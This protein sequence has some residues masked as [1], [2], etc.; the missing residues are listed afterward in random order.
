MRDVLA[1]AL[2]MLVL[3]GVANGQRLYR[4][5]LDDAAQQALKAMDKV[6]SKELFD[7]MLQNLS[8]QSRQDFETTFSGIRRQTRDRIQT[9]DNWCAV[10]ADMV[11]TMTR[12]DYP[13]LVPA[14]PLFATTAAEL[15]AE[16]GRLLEKDPAKA[17]P[18]P[19]ID[20][21]NELVKQIETAK[22]D[23]QKEIDDLTNNPGTAE[24]RL[25]ALLGQLGNLTEVEQALQ[26]FQASPSKGKLHSLA[27][28]ALETVG[29]LRRL[30]EAYQEF[31]DRRDQIQNVQQ[32]LRELR[33]EMLK[34]AVLKLVAQEEHLKRLIAIEARRAREIEDAVASFELYRTALMCER[35]RNSGLDLKRI[36]DSLREL[37]QSAASDKSTP[38]D[39]Y[40]YTEKRV[41]VS[42][43][44]QVKFLNFCKGTAAPMRQRL[45]ALA[46]ALFQAAAV[47]TRGA[48]PEYLAELRRAQEQQRYSIVQSSLEARAYETL[49]ETGV[50]RLALLHAGGIK[51]S[52]IAQLVYQAGQLAG[53]SVI[54]VKQ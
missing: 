23:R 1:I 12:F 21:W 52:E 25:L 43:D 17:N 46:R 51:P 39:G 49:V 10:H 14:N 36:D 5:D 34:I 33:A 2:T 44:D 8:M 32:E 37:G 47:Q 30:G 54:A 16:C 41:N 38:S 24:P 31:K 11:Q 29:I 4:K 35:Q 45:E 7:R 26:Q 40:L 53:V 28:P 9:W 19:V 3:A 6:D 13:G 15:Q 42:S 18:Q 48:T 22:A 27:A 20:Q 50:R